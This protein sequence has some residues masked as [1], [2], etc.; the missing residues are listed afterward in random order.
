M[1]GMA[2]VI[3][4][5]RPVFGWRRFGAWALAGAAAGGLV[6][7]VDEPIRDAV[8]SIPMGGDVKRELEMLQQFGGFASIVVVGAIIGLLQRWRFR[9]MLDW[10][11]AAG[12]GWIVFG[13]M[14]V[15]TGRLRPRIDH[16]GG[17]WIGPAGVFIEPK[18]GATVHPYEFWREGVYASMS[19]PST[20]TTHAAI[21]A[22]FLA[23]MYPPLRWMAVPMIGLVGFSR[24]YFGSHW[25]SD[26]VVGACLGWAWG[27]V[28]CQRS[29]G[30]RL[31]DWIWRRAVDRHAE[32]ALPGL[33]ERERR[34]REVQ[35][36]T[37]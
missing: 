15:A 29:W 20:H 5:D 11:L 32:P 31:V 35:E 1:G 13:V 7:A 18:S 26:V 10:G 8:R 17:S 25:P 19:M 22:A 3:P 4:T 28:V 14:K 37:V 23:T 6:M 16:E 24:V 30:V 9:R 27:M 2:S 12:L 33:V 36:S 34:W 21:A